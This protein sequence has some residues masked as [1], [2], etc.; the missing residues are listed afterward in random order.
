MLFALVG[1]LIV[2]WVI[3]GLGIMFAMNTFGYDFIQAVTVSWPLVA[4]PWAI[5]LMTPIITNPVVLCVIQLGWLEVLPWSMAGWTL[6]A[7]RYVFAFS[8]D[9]VFPV[10]L[11]DIS[12]RFHFPVKATIANFV[13]ACIFFALAAFTPFLGLWLN[14]IAITSLVWAVASIAAIVLP[15][16][17]KGIADV[18]PGKSWKIPLVSIL[19]FISMVSMIINFYWDATTPAIGPS[20]FQADLMLLGIL[21]AGIVVFVVSYLTRKSQGIDLRLIYSQIPPE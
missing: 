9:R 15:F 19:G 14:S 20:T 6:V 17:M 4:P 13:V 5:F 7:T 18:L 11:A 12:D 2:A 21:I 10:K 8:F 1:S 16:K 3:D